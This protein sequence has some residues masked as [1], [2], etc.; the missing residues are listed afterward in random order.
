[1]GMEAD[2]RHRLEKIV[3]E[4]KGLGHETPHRIARSIE[5]ILV[6]D[7]VP[8]RS[9]NVEKLTRTGADA[10]MEAIRAA[11]LWES[12]NSAHE[13]F[14]VLLEEVEEL[15]EH[16]W[17]NQKRRDLVAMEKEAIQVAAMAIRFVHDIC[18][19]QRG[20]R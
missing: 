13:G 1:M 19:E 18:N 10:V 14:G 12:F 8:D 9:T 16:V 7:S 3:A 15:K 11:T 2:L 4:M 17:M 6:D 5:I 20:R